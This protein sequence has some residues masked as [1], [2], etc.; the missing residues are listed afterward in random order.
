MMIVNYFRNDVATGRKECAAAYHEMHKVHLFLSDDRDKGDHLMGL[1]LALTALNL[2]EASRPS[3]KCE[4][5][6]ANFR[7]HVYV[8]L[9]VR[10][11]HS[12]PRWMNFLYRFYMFKGKRRHK[13]NER[14]DANLAWVFGKTG[15][16]FVGRCRLG[17]GDFTYL[18]S[19][20]TNMNP[21]AVV[22]RYFR[23]E[24]LRK[25]LGILVSPGEATGRIGE[26][27]EAVRASEANNSCVDIGI[28]MPCQ[29]PVSRWWAS[30]FATAAHWAMNEQEQASKLY[31]VEYKTITDSK[32][33]M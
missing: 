15:Q 11:R 23:E 13:D 26:A 8:L 9:A 10:A 21:L 16:E 31:Q 17:T 6:P 2:T 24:Q 22:G 19:A 3:D 32:S 12:L 29:D 28:L 27:L 7:A 1:Y 14:I 5:L 18:T 25:A 4:T 30:V 20:P 33:N